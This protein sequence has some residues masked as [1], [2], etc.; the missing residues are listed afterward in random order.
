MEEDERDWQ[1]IVPYTP[2]ART[3]PGA[4]TALTMRSYT[5]GNSFSIITTPSTSTEPTSFGN[6][7]TTPISFGPINTPQSGVP[8][9]GTKRRRANDENTPLSP[10][11]GNTAKKAKNSDKIGTILACIQEQ[12]WTLGEFLYKIFDH[13]GRDGSR[14]QKHA[15]MVKS[16]L[17]GQGNYTPSHILI[18]WMSSPDGVLHAHDPHLA[19][20]YSANTPYTEIG[21]IRPA[22]TSFAL[23]MVGNLLARGAERAVQASSG[24]QVI[25][26]ALA[27]L[28][29]CRTDNANLLPLARGVLYFGCSGLSSAE[30]LITSAHGSDPMKAGILLFDNV[31]NLAHVRDHRIGRENHMNVGM[32]GLWRQ[33]QRITYSER[34]N[35]SVER[36]FSFLDQ[37]DADTTGHLAWLEVLGGGQGP[38]CGTA[39]LVIPLEKSVV[40]VLAPSGKKQTIPSELKD[41]SGQTATNYLPRKLVIG[42]DGL[43]YAMVLQLQ[44]YL[45]WHQDAFKSLE[46]LEPQLQVWHLKWTDIIRIFQTHW[47]RTSG[48]STNPASLGHSAGKIGRSA[49]S[50]M[51]KVEFYP[52]SQLLYLVLDARMLDCWS[53]LLGTNDIFEYFDSLS[54]Q[55]KLPDLEELVEMA[56]KLHRTYS[57]ARARDHA[58][59]DTGTTTAWARTVPNGSAWVP[60]DVEDSSLDT[61]QKTKKKSAGKKKKEKVPPPL[62]KG[63]FVLAQAI[64]FIRDGMNSR[65]MATAVAEGDVGR[66]YECIKYT[67]FT[68]AGST[69]SNY[70]N[71]VLETI[72]NLEL[73]SSPGLREALLLCLLI[74]LRGLAGHFEEG[75]YVVEFFNRL[76]EDIVQH[77]NAQFDDLFI[78]NLKLAWRASSGMAAKSHIHSDPHTKPEMR[79]LLKLYRTEELHSR[80]LGRQIDDRDTDDFAKGVKKLREGALKKFID[81]S[82]H[83][84]QPR[85]KPTAPTTSTRDSSDDD[86]GDSSSEESHDD[87]DADTNEIYATRGSMSVVDG[88]LVMDGRDMMD[89]P[90]EEILPEPES[91]EEAKEDAEDD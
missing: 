12:G 63:D 79:T 37:E 68:F 8:L 35:L 84:R 7:W 87:S 88:E 21:P 31:Q 23:Q 2:N 89:G 60:I 47:G 29:F 83:T 49:P 20:M 48:K 54:K 36:L 64:D 69:H 62:C 72:V 66:L 55:D 18:C 15:Q 80:R 39:K 67:L 13:Q 57:T 6:T 28:L 27:D 14:S 5:G 52:G 1:W 90:E 82:R 19:D 86:D 50:K 65:K 81:K 26:H 11:D 45:Q 56:K 42:G 74:N 75:D 70:L 85:Q 16:F 22:L 58:I 78:R 10:V 91:E 53:L 9:S 43:S 44:A 76:L 3:P 46:I 25:T 51:K 17:R 30:A 34:A 32:S 4:G 38:Y 24:L 41:A 73:E 33:R 40:H 77:K 71:Y 59:H 61:T